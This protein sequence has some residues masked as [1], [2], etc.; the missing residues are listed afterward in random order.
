MMK[1]LNA[2]IDVYLLQQINILKNLLEIEK[3][4]NLFLESRDIDS[5]ISTQED[6]NRLFEETVN[7]HNKTSE[8]ISRWTQDSKPNYDLHQNSSFQDVVKELASEILAMNSMNQSLV[9]DAMRELKV[10][11]EKIHL[12]RKA[13][14]SYRSY[15]DSNSFQREL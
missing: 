12:G 10:K 2:N 13:L 4:K 15:T 11:Q 3:R 5:A 7:L 6:S 1:H 9:Q 8:L 14:A